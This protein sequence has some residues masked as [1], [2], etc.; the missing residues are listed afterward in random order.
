MV[1]MSQLSFSQT[2]W[3]GEVLTFNQ[4]LNNDSLDVNQLRSN[5]NNCLGVA[6]QNDEFSDD[7]LANYV[8]LGFG[9]EL[10]VMMESS[11]KNVEGFDFKVHETTFG[12]NCERYPETIM[13]FASQDNCNWYF[14]GVGCHDALFDLGDLNWAK[15]IKLIDTSPKGNFDI[16]A[17]CDG[18]DVDGVEGFVVET[19]LIPTTLIPNSAQHVISF[20][21]GLRKN[22]TPVSLSRSNP[23][24]AI[25]IPQG[26]ENVNFVSL[27]L[28]GELI[29]KFDFTVFNQSGDDIKIVETTYANPLCSDYPEKAFIDVSMDG[30]TFV[31]LGE[32]CLDSYIELG[33]IMCFQYI[34][35]KD[36]SAATDFSSS[37]DGYDV[38]GVIS[39]HYCDYHQNRVDFDDV[40]TMNDQPDVVLSPN[41]FDDKIMI[42]NDEIKNVIIYNYIGSKVKEFLGVT[43][44]LNVS[45][46]PE[47]IYYLDIISKE[48]RTT[49]KLVKK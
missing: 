46:L 26:T 21:Q 37:S 6:E 7:S 49:H 8:S 12:S 22:G 15:Y 18:Y 25:G 23:N 43:D 16:F 2:V 1:I 9:G 27:G 5:P 47:G 35:I 33:D 31:E 17:V 39:L 11:I 14:C 4:G 41:P 20:N 45:D 48:N 40:I 29:L 38:D 28:G 36:R 32:V 10:T 30:V 24:N 44:Q 42:N 13:A 3:V 19:D 34:R